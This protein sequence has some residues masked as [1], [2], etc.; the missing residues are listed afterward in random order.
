MHRL[1]VI[2]VG[3]GRLGSHLANRLSEVGH[4]IVTIDRI[5][6]S[7]SA[8]SPVY[9]GFRVEGDATELSILESTKIDKADIV[10]VATNDDNINIMVAQIASRIFGVRRVIARVYDPARES[11]YRKLGVATFSPVLLARDA[12]LTWMEESIDRTALPGDEK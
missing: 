11:I 10:I 5:S 2:V 4:N 12:V 8:L 7:F 9:S 3:C 6:S 1:F